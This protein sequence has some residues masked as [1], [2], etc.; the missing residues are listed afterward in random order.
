M[1][2]RH[3]EV[4]G[5]THTFRRPGYQWDVGLHYIGQ[6]QAWPSDVRRV[7]D[8]LT[9][10]KVEWQ[11]MPEVYD[12]F[13]IAGQQFEFA[14]GLERFREGLRQS[15]PGE[16]GAIDRYIAA[17]RRVTGSADFITRRRRSLGQLRIVGRRPDA[18]P[19]YALGAAYHARGVGEL[20]NERGTDT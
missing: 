18:R 7:F 10:G 19:L 20:Y 16:A 11:A 2:E 15:F 12:R 4:G 1:L 13:F 3:Y 9:A 17:V 6:M 5:F 14:A 8:H